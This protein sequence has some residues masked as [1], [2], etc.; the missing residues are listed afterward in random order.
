MLFFRARFSPLVV[1]FGVACAI[2]KQELERDSRWVK[3][4]SDRLL[5]GLSDV[6]TIHINTYTRTY[7]HRKQSWVKS[8]V[9]AC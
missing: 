9:A 5:K 4:L 2:A 7:T 6:R 8:Y 3:F 1:G